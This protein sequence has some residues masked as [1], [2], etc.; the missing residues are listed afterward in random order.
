MKKEFF[1]TRFIVISLV[2]SILFS[3]SAFAQQII[4]RIVITSEDTSQ[5]PEINISARFLD[6]T[7]KNINT[8]SAENIDIYE[9]GQQVNF[10][11]KKTY[12]GLN[13]VILF[14]LNASI[15][16]KGRSGE[17]VRD[18]MRLAALQFVDTMKDKDKLVIMAS[19]RDQVYLLQNFSADKNALKKFLTDYSFRSTDSHISFPLDGVNSALERLKNSPDTE[20]NKV[21]ILIS[22]GIVASKPTNI[23]QAVDITSRFASDAT[24][25]IYSILV[26]SEFKPRYLDTLAEN[27]AGSFVHFEGEASVTKMYEEID[28][29]RNQYA[30]TYKTTS[31]KAGERTLSIMRSKAKTPLVSYTYSV[32]NPPQPPRI[33]SFTINNGDPIIRQASDW[34]SDL[35]AISPTEVRAVINYDWPDGYLRDLTK[36]ELLIDGQ[37]VE[38]K[39]SSLTGDIFFTINLRGVIDPGSTTMVVEGRI[40][41]EL[42]FEDSLSQPVTVEVIVPSKPVDLSAVIP[43]PVC[44]AL[45]TVPSIGSTLGPYCRTLGITPTA[46][47]N[48]GLWAFML[49]L[50]GILWVNRTKVASGIQETGQALTSMYK[51]LTQQVGGKAPK[52]RLEALQGV[53]K[54][55]RNV[56]DLFGETPVGRDKEYAELVFVNHLSISREHCIFH[57]DRAT[58][59]W[60]VEDRDSANG[61]YL[62]GNKLDPFTRYPINEGDI[63]EMSQVERGGIK[64]RFYY[65]DA[66]DISERP[67][68]VHPTQQP[69]QPDHAVGGEYLDHNKAVQ[70][71]YDFFD[72]YE[73]EI[74]DD[75]SQG[76]FSDAADH[77][78]A[79]TQVSKDTRK[80]RNDLDE[81]D[82]SQHT[83]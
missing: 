27:N 63:V 32:Q 8:I 46:V 3:N 38:I 61:T 58:G 53:E 25:P 80:I 64:F 73:S 18:E 83:F 7:N 39:T 20:I 42:G 76:K 74:Q 40:Q 30:I 33:E 31:G 81:F 57:E 50:V 59:N 11:I 17:S 28:Q 4:E 62:N 72:A 44:D 69:N 66:D 60:S 78:I 65:L 35:S 21:I 71:D 82:P 23:S 2:L 10:D 68:M 26:N 1:I 67:T 15:N 45:E 34:D 48:F 54:G 75:Q 13:A 14:D 6:R 37:T 41:D 79:E 12:M 47:I 36:A 9:D 49:V 22:S 29:L 24:I 55:E 77:E 16:V 19:D 43:M 51:R 70:Q 56:F 5:F 52:A